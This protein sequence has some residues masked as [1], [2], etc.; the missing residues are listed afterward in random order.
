MQNYLPI[1]SHESWRSFLCKTL[2]S[3]SSH[4]D[5]WAVPRVWFKNSNT[6][7]DSS[8]SRF[9]QMRGSFPLLPGGVFSLWAPGGNHP[10]LLESAVALS[11]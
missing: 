8:I 10:V 7:P 2:I 6:T 4:D 9:N 11:M 3:F 5:R 1:D